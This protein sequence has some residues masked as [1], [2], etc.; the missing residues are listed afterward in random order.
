MNGTGPNHKEK[1]SMGPVPIIR[2]L[3]KW[4]R[5]RAWEKIYE[6]DRTQTE[7]G[8]SYYNLLYEWHVEGIRTAPNPGRP[9][10]YSEDFF[11]AIRIVR[12]E[13][14]LNIKSLSLKV[15]YKVLPENFVTTGVDMGGFHF[16]K[17]CKIELEHPEADWDWS[18]SLAVL[19]LLLPLENDTW[20]PPYTGKTPQNLANC[21]KP[22][23]H[24]MPAAGYSTFLTTTFLVLSPK[25]SFY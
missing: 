7:I 15:W 17:R 19:G 5:S 6:W 11:N 24:I 14:L 20:H 23:L 9:P 8:T 2:K 16:D 25:M 21:H 4:D 10:N 18:W 22:S 12:N 3:H 1:S 13:G